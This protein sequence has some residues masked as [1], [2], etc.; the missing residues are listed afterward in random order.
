MQP[1]DVYSVRLLNV[2]HRGVPTGGD[3]LDGR[4]V[5]LVQNQLHPFAADLIEPVQSR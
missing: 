1:A 5:I 2:A 3:H 4:Q